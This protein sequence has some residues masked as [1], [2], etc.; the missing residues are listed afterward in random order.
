[1][2]SKPNHGCL[3]CQKRTSDCLKQVGEPTRNEYFDGKAGE[4]ITDFECTECGARWRYIEEWGVGGHG[5][6]WSPISNQ[7]D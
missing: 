5:K 3:N 4:R 7:K 6:S 1:M 2:E